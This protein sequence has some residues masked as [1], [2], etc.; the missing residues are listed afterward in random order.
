MSNRSFCSLKEFKDNL[1]IT[2]STDDIAIL[3]TLEGATIAIEKFCNRRFQPEYG[4]KY[5]AGAN[6]IWLKPDL[7][8]VSTLK[9]DEDNDG[10]FETT[11]TTSDYNLMPLNEYPKSYIE[12]SDNSD[13][14][15]FGAGKKGLEIV[16]LFGYG[17][18]ESSTPYTQQSQTLSAMS[19]SA[20]TQTVV[21]TN[22]AVGQ[23]WL[24]DSEQMYCKDLTTSVATIVR[25]VNGTSATTHT[26]SSTIYVF[27][28]PADIKQACFDLASAK[29][30]TRGQMG[31]RSQTI[32]DYSYTLNSYL[33][34]DIIESILGNS[35]DKYRKVN[36]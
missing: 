29:W 8:S 1:G 23:T 35:I 36:I 16:G 5:F 12:I 28:Y 2:A 9:T 32:G 10:T 27:D 7:L 19:A 4:T 17:D 26:A 30:N 11:Y 20:S 14:G 15:T 25:S 6:R 34:K 24:I 13:Y 3:K 33:E 31:M 21:S 18:G 22:L